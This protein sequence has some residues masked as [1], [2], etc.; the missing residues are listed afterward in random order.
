M[1]TTYFLSEKD[2]TLLSQLLHNR[3]PGLFP[4]P[5]IIDTLTT[6]LAKSHR[7]SNGPVDT[8]HFV[9]IGDHV[10]L[11][12]PSDHADTYEPVIVLPA[13][14]D[15]ASDRLSVLT[16]LGLAVIGRRTGQTVT[17]QTPRGPR[18]MKIASILKD[19]AVSSP[20]PA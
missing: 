20:T 15:L 11:V 12:S 7:S 14:S 5:A 2:H 6:L 16:P 19:G 9:S 13:D 4:V 8:E 18:E 17:W 1:Q 3:I 10:M